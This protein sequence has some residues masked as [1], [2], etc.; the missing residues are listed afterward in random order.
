MQVNNIS[1]HNN[2]NP[3]FKAL[4]LRPGSEKYISSMPDKVLDK[5]DSVGE[6]LKET[7]FYHLDVTKD[8][9]FITNTNGERL[10]KPLLI[11]NAGQVLIIKAKQ[12]LS[13]ISQK[14]KF[15][16]LKEV[17]EIENKIKQAPTQLERT[18]EIAKVLDDYQNQ[19]NNTEKDIIIDPKEPR[20][21]KIK[22]LINKYGT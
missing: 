2:S 16:S 4:R 7:K 14:L 22:K 13:Q 21:E 8:D 19:L 3:Q 6:Y 18:A 9:F 15:K 10:Y 5:L 11:T 1:I 20:E 12:G 17:S